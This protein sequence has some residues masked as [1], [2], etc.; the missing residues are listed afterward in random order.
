MSQNRATLN[1]A[2]RW[3]L[4]SHDKAKCDSYEKWTNAGPD[5]QESWKEKKKKEEVDSTK[6][7]DGSLELLEQLAPCN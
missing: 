2:R 7:L 6:T 1:A 4:V 5:S 3:K